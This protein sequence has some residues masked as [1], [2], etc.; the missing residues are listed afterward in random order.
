MAAAFRQIDVQ[1]VIRAFQ[2]EGVA[3]RVEIEPGGKIIALP[4]GAAQSQDEAEDVERRM[5]AAFGE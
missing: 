1:R 2:A 3:V 5:K 4:A